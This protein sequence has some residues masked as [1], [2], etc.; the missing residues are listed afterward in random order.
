[1]NGDFF[2]CE[3]I[4]DVLV[5]TL[6]CDVGSF[7]ADLMGQD[8]HE[9]DRH[10]GE[11]EVP[12][13]L[14]DFRQRAYF[15]SALLEALLHVWGIVRKRHG[16]MAL[17][18]VSPVGRELLGLARFRSL[19]PICATREEALTAVHAEHPTNSVL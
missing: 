1:M 12:R 14:I 5:I 2:H 6:R 3:W 18:N 19:W 11:I 17:Y 8:L 7:A 10:L 16:R 9:I 15:G 13:V 4:D